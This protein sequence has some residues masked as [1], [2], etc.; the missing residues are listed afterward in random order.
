[1]LNDENGISSNVVF[2]NGYLVSGEDFL[3]LKDYEDDY[4]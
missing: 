3:N 2:E 4:D 1:M